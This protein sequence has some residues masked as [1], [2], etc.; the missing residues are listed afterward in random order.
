MWFKQGSN[1]EARH[2]PLD[3]IKLEDLTILKDT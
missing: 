1:G 2:K 3:L